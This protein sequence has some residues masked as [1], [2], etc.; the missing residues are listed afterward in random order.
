MSGGELAVIVIAIAV[1]AIVKS[2]TGMGLPII[3][4]PIMSVFIGAET[5]VAAIALPNL[6]QN[7]ALVVRHRSSIV[8]AHYLA[9][10]ALSGIIGAVIG[11]LTLGVV[12]ESVTLAVLLAALTGYI[13]TSIRQP[14]L[15][16][17]DDT[18]RRWSSPVGA[19]AGL[20]QGAI[21]ISGPIV[22]TWHHGL[23]LSRD[24]FVASVSA[25]F[26]ISGASQVV[27]LATRNKFDGLLTVALILAVFVL[28]T[29]PL[30]HRLANRLSAE[31]FQHA[32]LGLLS[33]SALSIAY[34]LLEQIWS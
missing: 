29:I 31:R 9:R 2:V 32:I 23:R 7:I 14:D 3:A 34:R 20:F 6:A 21:G 19:V 27:V 18:A 33:L 24:A 30:G 12:P 11:T 25:V 17:A 1:G 5:A 16:L 4:V 10:F 13:V 22:G 8:Q 26:T 15:Q 28:A